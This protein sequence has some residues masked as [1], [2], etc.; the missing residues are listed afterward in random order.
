MEKPFIILAEMDKMK[1]FRVRKPTES[2]PWDYH[3]SKESVELNEPF[4][5]VILMPPIIG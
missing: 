1:F 4:T 3:L 2:Q 5:T